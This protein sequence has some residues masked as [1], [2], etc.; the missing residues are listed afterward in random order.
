MRPREIA[1][2]R[3]RGSK[4]GSAY[5]VPGRQQASVT[6]STLNQNQGWTGTIALAESFNLFAI[7]VNVAAWVRL[8]VTPAARSADSTRSIGTDP[9]DG[10]GV[11]LEFETTTTLL[12]ASLSPVVFGYSLETPPN[13]NIAIAITRLATGSGAVT[14]TL[15]YQPMGV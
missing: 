9:S 3:Q 2:L 11:I 6:T 10:A 7:D 12:S 5:A 4:G 8:Y 13:S 14:V 15:D 1:A